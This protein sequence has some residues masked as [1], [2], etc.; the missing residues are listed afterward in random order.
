MKIFTKQES[1]LIVNHACRCIDKE[2]KSQ[3]ELC[4]ELSLDPSLLTKAKQ[5]KKKLSDQYLIKLVE[6]YGYPRIG[7][8]LFV[9]SEFYL[10]ISDFLRAYDDIQETRF[11]NQQIDL[12]KNKN[13]IRR[14]INSF[15]II[16]GKGSTFDNKGDV[17][18]HLQL[19][20]KDEAFENWFDLYE[21]TKEVSSL[22]LMIHGNQEEKAL[23][24]PS[25]DEVLSYYN[26]NVHPDVA[27]EAIF[28]R[29]GMMNYQLNS[30][31]EFNISN[32]KPLPIHEKEMVVSGEL[33]LDERI[34]LSNFSDNTSRKFQKIIE[35]YSLESIIPTSNYDPMKSLYFVSDLRDN[36]DYIDCWSEVLFQV[37]LGTDMGYHFI[38]TFKGRTTRT[39]VITIENNNEIIS[40]VS[41][42]YDFF[43][44][45]NISLLGL[46]CSLA[47]AG[48]YIPGTT[49]LT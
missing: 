46:K 42:V 48:A 21:P 19:M 37:Y 22:E 5:G 12:W 39:I 38:L 16:E 44:Q 28:Q 49:L 2:G 10:G 43:G 11:A 47:K 18:E 30:I 1:Q 24:E 31:V 4:T 17:I 8:G 45:Q 15:D 23:I 20:L 40:S 3:N 13:F 25:L 29:L 14:I 35:Q 41:Q 34:V 9:E 6:T 7:K 36:F 33:I 26:I 27:K 32:Q